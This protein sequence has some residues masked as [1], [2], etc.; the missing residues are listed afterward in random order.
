MAVAPGPLYSRTA[1]HRCLPCGCCTHGHQLLTSCMP[2]SRP[3]RP[4]APRSFV[5]SI[6]PAPSCPCG[7][8][9]RLS[10]HPEA[11]PPYHVPEEANEEAR[12]VA[13]GT[14]VVSHGGLQAGVAETRVAYVPKYGDSFTLHRS[15][16]GC[17]WLVFGSQSQSQRSFVQYLQ[18]L[19]PLVRG[20]RARLFSLVIGY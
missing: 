14:Q 3:L 8:A 11:G 15:T 12:G 1:G 2:V 5:V 16:P 19:Q 10:G 6:G 20:R 13:C 7:F 17:D 18:L 9:C 4:A